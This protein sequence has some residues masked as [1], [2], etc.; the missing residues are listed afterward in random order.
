MTEK[1]KNGRERPTMFTELVALAPAISHVNIEGRF[2]KTGEQRQVV[3]ISCYL[4]RGSCHR[5]DSDAVLESDGR[6]ASFG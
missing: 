5:V 3:Q 6:R 1:G 4:R 2:A